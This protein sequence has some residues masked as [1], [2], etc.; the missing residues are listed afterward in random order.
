[1]ILRCH[2]TDTSSYINHFLL[3]D[4][5]DP[6]DCELVISSEDEAMDEQ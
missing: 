6:A 5:E 4:T 1:M 3:S 2:C